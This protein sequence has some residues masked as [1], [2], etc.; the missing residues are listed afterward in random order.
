MFKKELFEWLFRIG[1]SMMFLGLD[2]VTYTV[3]LKWIKYLTTAGF[4]EELI[5]MFMPVFSVIDCG[6]SDPDSPCGNYS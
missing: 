3:P 2:V 4:T 6:L 1:I 5:I